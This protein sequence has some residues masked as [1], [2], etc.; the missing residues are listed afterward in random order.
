[1]DQE[2]KST[3][4]EILD[5]L[6]LEVNELKKREVNMPDYTKNFQA[7]QDLL[8][9]QLPHYRNVVDD[10]R[11]VVS[12][13]NLSYPAKEIQAHLAAMKTRVE[14]LPEMIPVRHEHRFDLKSKGWIISGMILLI[15]TAVATGLAGYLI[16]K[17]S[18]YYATTLKYRLAKQVAPRVTGW[19]D[20]IFI[21]DPKGFEER[22]EQME[23]GDMVS[24]A[25]VKPEKK[26]KVKS[27]RKRKRG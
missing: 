17:N 7:L 26:P 13:H 4:E 23:I 12:E 16:S 19:I 2:E 15:V 14:S 10:P 24:V 5:Q 6:I 21:K 27:R 9:E 20:S 3:Q 22:L 1:M 8:T 25:K 18:R 11:Q